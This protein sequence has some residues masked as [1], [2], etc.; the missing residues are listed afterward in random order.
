MLRSTTSGGV[1]VNDT[2]MHFTQEGLPFGG[3]GH[4]GM[5]RYHGVAGFETFSHLK[6]VFEQSRL[7]VT[8][9]VLAGPV[10]I[11]RRALEVLI[12]GRKRRPGE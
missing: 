7:S 5:G 4:S 2:L 3:V 9:M 6:G 12:G 1:S 10:A 11:A 8:P